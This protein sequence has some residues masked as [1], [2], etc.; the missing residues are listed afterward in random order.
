[1]HTQ[2][3]VTH[4]G[5]GASKPQGPRVYRFSMRT[6]RGGEREGI[7]A[8]YPSPETGSRA[9]GS[10]GF[11]TIGYGRWGLEIANA[12]HAGRGKRG[13]GAAEGGAAYKKNSPATTMWLGLEADPLV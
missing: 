7:M 10:P 1:M 4:P 3:A 2:G 5:D 8:R 13:S 12:E 9:P 6:R 11:N